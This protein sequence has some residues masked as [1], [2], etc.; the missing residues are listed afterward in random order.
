MNKKKDDFTKIQWFI[1]YE[2]HDDINSNHWINL[3]V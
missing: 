1:E 2:A 3:S